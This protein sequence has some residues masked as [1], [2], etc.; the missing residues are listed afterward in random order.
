MANFS[1]RIKELISER[2]ISPKQLADAIGVAVSS[3][4]RWQNGKLQIYL[5]KLIKIADYFHCS[6]DFLTGRKE[7]YVSYPGKICLPFP[8]RLRAVLQEK[9]V[10]TYKLRKETQVEG[11]Y[12]YK[13]DR[14][15]DPHIQTLIELADYLDITIDYLVGREDD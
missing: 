14:G 3:V 4:H 12:F 2:D 13:W 8:Q 15:S 6:L 5:S 1:E 10:S 7:E 9:G 11:C